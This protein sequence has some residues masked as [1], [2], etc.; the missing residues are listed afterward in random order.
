MKLELMKLEIFLKSC[1]ES[2]LKFI[3]IHSSG[4][5]GTA[6]LS[7]TFGHGE[8][9]KNK[10]H[11]VNDG[12]H[13]VTQ[14][15]WK[16]IYKTITAVKK[17]DDLRDPRAAI[18]CQEFLKNKIIKTK[19]EFPLVE[20]YMVTDH[21]VG[22]FFIPTLELTDLDYQ[23]IRITKKHNLVADSYNK[24]IIR[25]RKEMSFTAY[26]KFYKRFWDLNAFAHNDPYVVNKVNQKDWNKNTDF[27]KF[28]WFSKEVESQWKLAK[29]IIPNEKYIEV[30]FEDIIKEDGLKKIESF[31]KMSWSKEWSKVRAN[32]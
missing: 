10:I 25:R 21:R 27:D 20:K 32:K 8:F 3:M 9:S 29:A 18:I 13:L 19:R 12:K 23:V 5:T 2:K 14:E 26:E 30:S 11:L 15:S 17:F 6:F 16:D 1:V 31:T 24:R 28:L 22:R 7:Q 4:R